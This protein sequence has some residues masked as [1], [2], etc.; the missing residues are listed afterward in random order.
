MSHVL[1]NVE[2]SLQLK[3]TLSVD[4]T[5]QQPLQPYYKGW[6]D[7]QITSATGKLISHVAEQ[8]LQ[9]LLLLVIG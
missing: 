2:S 1:C 6:L 9:R 8:M 7:A 5:D 4:G 3:P